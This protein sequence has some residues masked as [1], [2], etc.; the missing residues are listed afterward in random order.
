MRTSRGAA[1]TRRRPSPRSLLAGRPIQQCTQPVCAGR[2]S[3]SASTIPTQPFGA[4][5]NDS[6]SPERLNDVPSMIPER[7][8]GVHRRRKCR[9]SSP[10]MTSSR[11]RRS[12]SIAELPD[13]PTELL[14]DVSDA[15]FEILSDDP[16]GLDEAEV[17]LEL[18][19]AK[20]AESR[21][22]RRR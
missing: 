20:P 14:P 18:N 17:A 15:S 11:L 4:F 22:E 6:L 13:A 1:V 16:S 19:A 10:P 21:E 5:V 2:S 9:S 3:W 7:R 12:R 8:N